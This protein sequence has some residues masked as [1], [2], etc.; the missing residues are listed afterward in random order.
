MGTDKRN[1][2]VGSRNKIK[3]ISQQKTALGEAAEFWK[4][5]IEQIVQSYQLCIHNTKS[6]QKMQAVFLHV[7]D[8]LKNHWNQ[9]R[10]YVTSWYLVF[11][12]KGYVKP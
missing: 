8:I 7:V 5:A 3:D 2:K 12:E 6:I 4:L 9:I 11:N 10:D 1:Q